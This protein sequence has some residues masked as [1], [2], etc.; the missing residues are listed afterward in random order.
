MLL[1]TIKTYKLLLQHCLHCIPRSSEKKGNKTSYWILAYSAFKIFIWRQL[2]WTESNNCWA[3]IIRQALSWG[4]L[5]CTQNFKVQVWEESY[6]PQQGDP[7]VFPCR[8]L[9]W[10]YLMWDVFSILILMKKQPFIGKKRKSMESISTN[11]LFQ[12]Q[13]Q[14]N[15]EKKKT[16]IMSLI[17]KSLVYCYI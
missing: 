17:N 6:Y 11:S 8:K 4:V 9:S 12:K 7:Y 3:F 13:K 10:F 14:K 5:Q 2:R 1:T 15:K 16:I